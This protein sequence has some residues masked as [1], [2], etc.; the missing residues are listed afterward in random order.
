MNI[1]YKTYLKV[2][3]K[4]LFRSAFRVTNR[5]AK[6]EKTSKSVTS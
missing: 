1:K 3:L 4:F 6:H 5:R 2:E